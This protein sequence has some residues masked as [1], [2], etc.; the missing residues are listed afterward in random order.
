VSGNAGTLPSSV[1]EVTGG[2][3]VDLAVDQ[4]GGDSL[5][6]CLRS[7]APMGMVVSINIIK[8]LP[9]DNIF[10]EMRTLLNRS[11]AI[12]TFS[13]HTL[14]DNAVQRRALMTQAIE[15]MARGDIKAPQATVLRMSDI[16][17]AHQM[18]DAGT[19]MGKIVL[20]P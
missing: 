12:R 2:K 13:M 11:L 18:L 16:Q 20:R 10:K 5:I 14:D 3:G 1:L 9:E 15:Q 8:G 7:L 17:Q 19:S 4:L 6:A